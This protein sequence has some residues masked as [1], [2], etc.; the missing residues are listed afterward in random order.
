[1]IC[2]SI[3]NTIIIVKNRS[4]K[5]FCKKF[6]KMKTDLEKIKIINNFKKEAT[7]LNEEL[8]VVDDL[9]SA[10]NRAAD[11]WYH[12]EEKKKLYDSYSFF[13]IMFDLIYFN[14]FRENL[15]NN[16]IPDDFNLKI[17][18][19]IKKTIHGENPYYRSK[20]KKDC[21]G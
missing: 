4:E 11:D 7:L 10:L 1:L 13:G 21:D 12:V 17:L 8:T 15:E 19:I 2:K 18:E 9:M 20:L 3:R 16:K 6:F 5:N 14:C